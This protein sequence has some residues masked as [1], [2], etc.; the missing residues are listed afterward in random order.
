MKIKI[1]ALSG[2]IALLS[3]PVTANEFVDQLTE[4]ANGKISEIAK[5]SLIISAVMV[6]NSET[7]GYEQAKIDQLDQQWRTE[8]DASN[9][10]LIDELLGNSASAY[11]MQMVEESEGLFT[12]VIVMDAMGLNVGQSAVT[13]DYWQGDEGKWQNTFAVGAGSIDI[14]EVDLDESTQIF[15]SQVSIPILGVDGSPIGAI[16]IGINIDSL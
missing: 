13:S 4:I 11:L 16:T 6:Q 15:Q 8:V 12:E 1:V 5:N 3:A 10:P 7:S 14:S 9:R 2:L